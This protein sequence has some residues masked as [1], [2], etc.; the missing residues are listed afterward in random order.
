LLEEAKKHRSK[1]ERLIELLDKYTL[2]ERI[3]FEEIDELVQL[4]E[5]RYRYASSLAEK[6]AISSF[7]LSIGV[8]FFLAALIPEFAGMVFTGGESGEGAGT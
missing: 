3:P 2:K 1:V 6:L 8:I 4:L 7:L 5:E